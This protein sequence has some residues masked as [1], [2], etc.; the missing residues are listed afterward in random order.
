L[1][2]K[3]QDP[4]RIKLVFEIGSFFVPTPHFFQKI[5][6][7]P[8]TTSKNL[9]KSSRMENPSAKKG[10]GRPIGATSTI[11]ITLAELLVKL[12]NDVNATVTVGRVWY[13]KYSNVPTA[14]VQDGDS[15]PQEILNQLDEEPVA[16]FT[17][18]Q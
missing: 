11:E 15:I 1:I 7:K 13:S 2:K 10:R 16:E 4:K 9:L 8:L 14:S 5:L 3:Q 18:S 17:I 6:R 12:N